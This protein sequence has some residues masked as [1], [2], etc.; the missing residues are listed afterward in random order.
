MTLSD[1]FPTPPL[2]A[3]LHPVCVILNWKEENS[4]EE[5]QKKKTLLIDGPLV[6]KEL[7]MTLFAL[8]RMSVNS[9]FSDAEILI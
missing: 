4:H 6:C 8:F 5:M 9:K 1:G 3:A 2:A 7:V